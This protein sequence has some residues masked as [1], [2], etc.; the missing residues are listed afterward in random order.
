[1]V[2]VTPPSAIPEVHDPEATS[3]RV[4]SGPSLPFLFGAFLKAGCLG[5]GGF[6]SLMSMV[7]TVLVKQKR[8]LTSEQV[9]DGVSLASLLPGPQAVNVVAYCGYKLRGWRGAWVAGFAVVLPSFVAMLALSI[10]YERYGKL[11]AVTR[12][13]HGF[14]P[15]VAAVIA[16]V[17]W[18]LAR[19]ALTSRAEVV[20]ASAS[21]V[22]LCIASFGLFG[23]PRSAQLYVTFGLVVVCGIAG[24]ALFPGGAAPKTAAKTR[25]PAVKLAVTAAGAVLLAVIGLAQPAQDPRSDL[26]LAST[27]SGLSVMLFGGGYVFIPM[28]QHHVVDVLQWV[29]PKEFVDAIALSQVMPGPILVAATFIGWAV[30]GF[31]GALVATI[32]IF[33]PPAVVMVVASQALEHVQ[34]SSAAKSALRGIR[35]AVVGMI[36]VAALVVFK[37]GLPADLGDA[38]SIAVAVAL[39]AGALVALLRYQVDVVWVVPAS[40]LLGWVLFP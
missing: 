24:R 31:T 26:A 36:A 29:T 6:V 15:A 7:E 11:D 9:L 12:L 4:A 16:S 2:L 39:F 14:V 13:F 21:A 38:R 33:T 20:L 40:G 3:A 25:F 32:A 17:V 35:C 30:T 8:L 28:I 22:A 5:F 37:S 10:L 27:F 1:M 19:K 23:F 18:R 34:R